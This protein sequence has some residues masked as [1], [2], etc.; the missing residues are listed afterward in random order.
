MYVQS[1]KEKLGRWHWTSRDE[2]E[3]VARSVGQGETRG[4]PLYAQ[5]GEEV[6]AR[7]VGRGE[8]RGGHCMRSRAR[9]FIGGR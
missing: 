2:K 5:S 1:D 6:V 4:W 8:M 9:S 3:V 7:S